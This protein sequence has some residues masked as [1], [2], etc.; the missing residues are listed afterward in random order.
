MMRGILAKIALAAPGNVGLL[1]DAARYQAD[2]IRHRIPL[3]Y[4]RMVVRAEGDGR[5]ERVVH[6]R[7]DA[8]WNVVPGTE[9]TIEADVLCI[10]YGFSPSAELLRLVGCTFDDDEDLGGAVVRR[11]PWCRTDVAVSPSPPGD[12]C[13][14]PTPQDV[15]STSGPSTTPT[16]CERCS[17]AGWT[18]SSPTAPTC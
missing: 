6:A 4:R 10:G 3:K 11:D 7:V 16:R 2:L 13:A 5:V 18:G 1:L 14:G 9:Q 15:P 17:T 12:W 8:D